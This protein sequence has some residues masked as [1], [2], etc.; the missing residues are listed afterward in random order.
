MPTNQR[1]VAVAVIIGMLATTG[2]T[3]LAGLAG[4]A[5]AAPPSRF[6]SHD[7]A[8]LA[9]AQ[10]AGRDTVTLLVAATPGRAKAVAS[11]LIALGGTLRYRDD[12]V[13]YLRAKMPVG[14]AETASRITGVDAIDLDEVVPVPDVS[15]GPTGDEGDGAVTPTP[16]PPPDA[17]TPNANP[18]LP[19]QDTG[20]AAFLAAHPEWD[21]R[22]VTVGI[23]DTGVDL[24]HPALRAT[25]TGERK[26]VDVIT[27]TDPFDDNDPT[28]VGMATQVKGPAFTHAG[29]AYTAPLGS[30]RF[31][32]FDERDPRLGGEVGNDVNR[33]GNPAGSSGRFGVLWDT[34]ADRVYV[35]TNQ[36]RDFTDEQALGEYGD[37]FDTGRFGTDNPVTDVRESMP[38]TIETDGKNKVVNI[39]IVSGAHGTHVAGIVA[40][41]GL[42]DGGMTGAAPG[43]K[44]KSLRA[45]LFI[46]G[47][48]S[49]ALVEGMIHLAKQE[50][51]D[52]INMSIGGLPALNDGNNTRARIYDRL[53]EQY[54]VQLFLSAGN[55]GAGLNTVGD[56]SVATNVMSVG[57]YISNATWQSNY[58]WSSPYTHNQHPFSSRGPREDGGFKPQ[59]IAPG[60]AISTTPL[61]QAGGPVGGTYTL[62]PGYSMFNG[63]SMAAPQAAGAAALLISAAQQNGAQHQPAQLRRALISTAQLVDPVRIGVHEQGNGLIDV[64]AAWGLL[65]QNIKP[66]AITASV[67]VRTVLSDFLATPHTGTGIY[68]REGVRA[69]DAYTRTYT[70]RRTS[71]GGGD[72]TYGVS[73]MGNDG[74]FSS[75]TSLVLPLNQ[76]VTFDVAV[77]PATAGVHS[78]ILRLDDSAT[79]A[80]DAETMN[81]VVAAHELS[82]ANGYATTISGTIGRNQATSH[83]VRVPA[84]TPALKVDLSGPSTAAG[85]GQVRFLRYTPLGTG[86]D[87]NTSTNCYL[88]SAG[89]CTNGSPSSRATTNP[90]A[91]VWEIVVE[92]RRT[93]DVLV[94][95]Y[96]I[97]IT[98]LGA[99]VSPNP[100]T[101]DSA[102]AHSPVD[103]SYT[104]TNVF[105][106]FTGRAQG[107]TF[108]SARRGPFTIGHHEVQT[109]ETTVTS[110]TTSLRA[111]I[112]SPSDV[113]ADLDLFVYNCT[114][115]DCF[116]AGQSADGDSEESVTV[117]NPAAGLWRI[118]VDGYA[119]P[120]GSTSYNY[121][122]V[123][124]SAAFGS[125]AVTDAFA[126]RAPG[127]VW[128]VPA[129]VTVKAAPGPGRVL[130]GGVEVRTDSNTL[131]GS[132]QVVV[133]GVS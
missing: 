124:T 26:V 39:G 73:W 28:W 99:T 6:D 51:V 49:H 112:G 97:T 74:T 42:F 88:P 114:T 89:T 133:E 69:G 23:V 48:T 77:A 58:G 9:D 56:P 70:F 47:C 123:F 130:L 115:G 21:G 57:T 81:V 24:D 32:V 20:A 54:N 15:P 43:A 11:D 108:G 132:G 29:V 5:L 86:A 96:A 113:A 37:T 52:V 117:N 33:D 16:Q 14:K 127:A 93:S 10:A 103:R 61:W 95:P 53:I 120:S 65:A 18:Y 104:L 27:G 82:A 111:T 71:G 101:L 122:D 63:T 62:P 68:D 55:S 22:G 85:T 3:T 107:T 13:A 64:P 78:A 128:T 12:D 4:P 119:V 50:N 129:T 76:P 105:G 66:V 87:S 41:N 90:M 94:A 79:P 91:G 17:A 38:F 60:A 34:A 35:D 110:G 118:V 126:T 36:N 8:L 40:G 116:L 2:V 44:I 31:G 46:A 30:F 102:P 121:V 19:T 83:F 100:D 106:A 45:C 80:V 84:G 25:T 131:V 98:L 75:G 72:R 125:V 109:Y 7:R 92:A 1:P 67:P 59:I